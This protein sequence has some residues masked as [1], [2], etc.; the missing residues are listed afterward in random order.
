MN[1]VAEALTKSL[2][3][4]TV[5]LSIVA[6]ISKII[7]C[8]LGAKLL[9]YNNKEVIQ[10]GVGMISRGEVAL[11]M[12]NKGIS[13]GLLSTQLFTPIVIMVLVTTL[14]TPILLKVVYRN[15]IS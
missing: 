1:G 14:V 4:F 13:I 9:K 2:I 6:I 10:I 7:G 8:G 12:A 3:L 11:I 5:I 15:K